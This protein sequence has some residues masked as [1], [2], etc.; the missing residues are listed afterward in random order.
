MTTTAETVARFDAHAHEHP[1]NVAFAPDGTVYV[2]LHAAATVWRHTPDGTAA[3]L[4]LPIT[5]QIPDRT[6]ANG[7]VVAAD[8]TALIAVRSNNAALSGVWRFAPDG[9][10][11]KTA[12][13]P[14]GTGL[15]G[16]AADA[17]GNLYV[18]DDR[19]GAI[20]CVPL[21]G[22]AAA[23]WGTD[24]DLT[25]DPAGAPYPGAPVYG[26]NGIKVHDSAVYVS[27]PSRAALL[28]FPFRA[29][30]TAGT[31]EKPYGKMRFE[32]VDDFAFDTAGNV[33]VTTVVNNTVERITPD[34]RT[35]PLLTAADGLDQP[36]AVAFDTRGDATHLYVTNAAFF[37]PPTMEP[38]ASLLRVRVAVPGAPLPLYPSLA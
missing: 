9:V 19:L 18:A 36:T 12:D 33:Y 27:N 4:A 25:P 24:L 15:N 23:V 37:T 2:T 7:L 35:A 30:G 3:T 10:A 38:R 34:G 22:H 1:E 28:R 29:D 5:G 11:T 17:R 16:M 13:L 32:N 31:I 21:G 26:A 20:W 8:G 14:A 6:R